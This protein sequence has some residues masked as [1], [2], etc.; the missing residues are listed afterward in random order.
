MIS[1]TA[2][3][4]C[5]RRALATQQGSII[6]SDP[7]A[8]LFVD[9]ELI[10]YVKETD[11]PVH[12]VLLRNRFYQDFLR[13]SKPE[14]ILHLGSGLDTNFQRHSPFQSISYFE[15]DVPEMITY[16]K[17]RL[18]KENLPLPNYISE[19]LS[20]IES[21]QKI[22]GH[23]D[24]KRKTTFLAEGVFMYLD[25]SFVWELLSK[26]CDY[27]EKT[28][29]IGFDFLDK[30]LENDPHHKEQKAKIEKKGEILRW[31]AR[32]EDVSQLLEKL[33]YHEVDF[34]DRDR[35]CQRYVGTPFPGKPF[36]SMGCVARP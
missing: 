22:L 18:A 29:T 16:K 15:V 27:V 25:Q 9:Q 24:P 34:W 20:S 21:F 12:G 33:G 7:Y 32:S 28:P 36:G 26:L 17:E 35:M 10:D 30:T 19:K 3:I 31:Y 6:I 8:K 1:S 4:I 14:Q 5:A 11:A 23:L 13:D 2:K